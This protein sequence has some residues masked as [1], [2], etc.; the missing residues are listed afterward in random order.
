MKTPLLD[1]ILTHYDEPWEVGEKFFEMLRLQRDVDLEQFR[2][3]IVQD[4]K[5]DSVDWDEY[6]EGYSFRHFVKTI[7]H[8]GPAAARN[9]GLRESDAKWVMFCDFDDLFTN[10]CS[11]KVILNVLDTD[12]TDMLWLESWREEPREKDFV[13]I[14]NENITCTFGKL[15]RR[16]ALLDNDIF[17]DETFSHY[18]ESAFMDDVVTL[19]PPHRTAKLNTPFATYMKTMRKGSYNYG[20]EMYIPIMNEMMRENII[21]VSKN[22]KRGNKAHVKSFLCDAIFDAYFALNS[23]PCIITE[24]TRQEFFAMYDKYKHLLANIDAST[25]QIALEKS[26]SKVDFLAQ[27]MYNAY[28]EELMPPIDVLDIALNWVHSLDPSVKISQAPKKKIIPISARQST[29]E[30]VVVYCGTRNTYT[31]M[32]TS[33]KSLLSFT[34][35]DRI[36]FLTEDDEFPQP[37]PDY[38]TNINVSHQEYFNET[39]PNFKN[40]W[41]YMCLMRSIFTKLLPKHNKILSLDIDIAVTDDISELFDIDLSGYYLAGVHEPSREQKDYINFGVVLMNLDEIR[42]DH[43]DDKVINMLNTKHLDCP[44]QTAF[45]QACAGRI[46]LISN[47]YNYTPHT[48]ITG[49]T[50]TPKI[51]HYAGIKYWKHYAQFREFADTPWDKLAQASHSVSGQRVAIYTGT[52]NQYHMMELSAKSLLANT[53]VDRI[54]FLIEEDAFPTPLPDCITCMNVSKQTY[55][56]E[57]GPNYNSPFSYLPMLRAAFPKM[58]PEYDTVLSLDNDTIIEKDISDLF[59]MDISNYYY[60]AALEARPGR[61]VQQPYFNTGVML[62]N[63]KKMRDDGIDTITIDDL[64]VTH[65]LN[66]SQDALSVSCRD[67][68]LLIPS[69]YNA[70]MFTAP[71]DQVSI[72]HLAGSKKPYFD[73]FAEPYN[74]PWEQIVQKGSADNA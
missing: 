9:A 53:R 43:I 29:S 36:Y 66:D 31:S 34:H 63:L 19:F 39:S 49:E 26:W 60:A 16:R 33:A 50:E 73:K 6:L 1:I 51:F 37:L 65:Y 2:V 41:S 13:N 74:M 42:R 45:S 4:G 24:A 12:D 23:N 7:V 40:P 22:E 72:R 30:R 38:I 46:K 48:C 27:Y 55:F 10:I 56:H 54:L 52:A 18:Y 21:N 25:L 20:K 35:V 59:D 44:E 28:R 32:V 62:M 71:T 61:A 15:F 5:N 58:F 67:H 57:A 70:C 47:D 11:L 69:R 8:A 68:I 17:F 64:N 3:I 14:V